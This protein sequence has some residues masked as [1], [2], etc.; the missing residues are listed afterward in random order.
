MLY[1]RSVRHVLQPFQNVLVS[2]ARYKRKQEG[3]MFRN[4]ILHNTAHDLCAVMCSTLNVYR[5]K[6]GLPEDY[7]EQI[8]SEDPEVNT[9]YTVTEDSHLLLKGRCLRQE[10]GR[11]TATTLARMHVLLHWC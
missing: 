11:T 1:T 5:I 4:K 7:L 6:D 2:F 10:V 9:E 8:L 3:W